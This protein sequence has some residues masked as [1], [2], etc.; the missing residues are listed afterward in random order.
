M[1]ELA[2][3]SRQTPEQFPTERYEQL[4][5][6]ALGIATA[7]ANGR[8]LALLMRSGVAAWMQAWVSYT[9]PRPP[10]PESTHRQLPA[11]CS[12]V[13]TILAEMAMAAAR[14]EVQA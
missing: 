11:V 5:S 2:P 7:Q 9:T 10:Q 1:S 8:G 3:R 6:A 13:V 14:T 4:R 12:G